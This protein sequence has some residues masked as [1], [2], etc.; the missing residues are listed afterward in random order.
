LGE[1][2]AG[3]DF[4]EKLAEAQGFGAARWRGTRLGAKERGEGSVFVTQALFNYFDFDLVQLLQ[5]HVD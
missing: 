1:K 5:F 2:L 4:R 3:V